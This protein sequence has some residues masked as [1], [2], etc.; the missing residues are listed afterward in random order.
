MG[1]EGMLSISRP[2]VKGCYIICLS[3][4]DVKLGYWRIQIHDSHKENVRLNRQNKI[5]SSS[6]KDKV[7]GCL[8]L[9]R[10][11]TVPSKHNEKS[12]HTSLGMWRS[13]CTVAAVEQDMTVCWCP[14][15]DSR[16]FFMPHP[17]A[18]PL[19]SSTPA[20]THSANTLSA[21]GEIEAWVGGGGAGGL[22]SKAIAQ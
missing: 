2:V 19:S 9:S 11:Q 7:R 14:E 1:R 22:A 18:P 20:R 15:A 21:M 4:L 6:C 5:S 12:A 3:R 13:E 16:A 10:L 17:G 8:T